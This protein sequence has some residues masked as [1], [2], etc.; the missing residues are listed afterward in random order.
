MKPKAKP[1]ATNTVHFACFTCRKAFKQPA[2]SNWN[3]D[4]PER[5]FDCPNCKQPMSRL[6][7]HFNAPP[8]L[9]TRQWHK[10]ELLY[11][12]G[13]RF[14]SGNSRLGKT[15]ETLASTIQYLINSGRDESDVRSKLK[16]IRETSP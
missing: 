14:V 1:T 16:Q 7:R 15:C 10:V 8:K 11:H 6:G 12:F 3:L 2:S 13:E 5:P 4:I 9:A